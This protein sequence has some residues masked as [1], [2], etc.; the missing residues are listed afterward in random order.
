M[1]KTWLN[2]T[3]GGRIALCISSFQTSLNHVL[4]LNRQITLHAITDFHFSLWP[5]HRTFRAE[6]N[7]LRGR[8]KN[9]PLSTTYWSTFT[10][11]TWKRLGRQSSSQWVQSNEQLDWHCF[12]NHAVPP[13]Q[14]TGKFKCLLYNVKR[15]PLSSRSFFFHPQLEVYGT[16]SHIIP[17]SCWRR[18]ELLSLCRA[19]RVIEINTALYSSFHTQSG[20]QSNESDNRTAAAV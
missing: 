16:L 1:C 17:L 6:T 13:L 18:G 14:L 15:L 4:F 8:N 5:R 2:W 9:A 12:L 10:P 20:L 11:I 7:G 3:W 19:L